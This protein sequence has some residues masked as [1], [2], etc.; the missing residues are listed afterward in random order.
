MFFYYVKSGGTA[1]AD[2]GRSATERTGSYAAM[3][4]S[5]YYD[6]LKFIFADGSVNGV[7]PIVSSDNV[8]VSD[9]HDHDYGAT[10]SISITSSNLQSVDDNN[11]DSYKK[12]ATE[13][14]TSGQ[15]SLFSGS[16]NISTSSG[17]SFNTLTGLLGDFI[18]TGDRLTVNCLD[19]NLE[20]DSSARQFR[21]D[22]SGNYSFK[23]GTYTSGSGS[24]SG[25]LA[26]SGCIVN[27][28]EYIFTGGSLVNNESTSGSEINIKNSDLSALGAN[29]LIN[30]GNALTDGDYNITLTRCSLPVVTQLMESG[31]VNPRVYVDMY[32]CTDF[33]NGA[34]GMFFE[35]HYSLYGDIYTDTLVH[36]NYSYDG[37][38][39]ASLKIESNSNTN[40]HNPASVKVVEIP[41]QDLSAKDKTYRVN[42]LINT[43]TIPTLSDT[44]FWVDLSHND[45][46]SLALGKIVASRNTD[47]LATGVELTTSAES[48]QGTLPANTKAY[49]VDITLSAASLPNVTN[50]NV[51]VYVNL[52]VPNADVYVC[53]A[54]QIG[55]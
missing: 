52:A 32:Q 14:T 9:L 30:V 37:T 48:W 43:D 6:N 15:L 16:D 1:T 39:K 45:N 21:F 55:V 5:A 35:Y 3:G 10:T 41:A 36:L 50:G 34:D 49:Q 44:D 33:I 2:A 22:S 24:S 8:R 31:Q 46:A 7:T 18:V 26:R 29:P 38:N 28:D 13:R 20:S 47:I 12:G 23:R 4:A 54:V 27:F 11:A 53:P 17:V 25:I 42:L 51:A 19:M 40:I